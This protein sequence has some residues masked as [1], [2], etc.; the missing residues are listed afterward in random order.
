[1]KMLNKSNF[2]EK[3]ALK[4]SQIALLK[5][6]DNLKISYEIIHKHNIAIKVNLNPPFFFIHHFKPFDRE[7]VTK[8]CNDKDL[9]YTILK[10]HINLPKWSSFLDPNCKLKYQSLSRFSDYTEILRYIIKE[11]KLPVIIKRNFGSAGNKVF[12]CKNSREIKNA[13]LN[14]YDRNDRYDYISLAQQYIEPQHEYRVIMYKGKN[15]LTYEKDTSQA[16]FKKNLSP[17]H[18]KNAKAIEIKNEKLNHQLENFLKP[19]YTQFNFNFIGADVIIDKDNNMWLIEINK[20]PGLK[21]FIQ[22]NGL[23][24]IVSMFETILKDYI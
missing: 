13:L 12:K 4:I 17:L 18:W 9:S 15:L 20:S 14:I 8:I 24:P 5:A 3:N 1:M 22:H 2:T 19:I 10:S 16:I 21:I 6:C 23:K 7:D 11:F